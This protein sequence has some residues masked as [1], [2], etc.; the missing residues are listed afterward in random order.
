MVTAGDLERTLKSLL[1]KSS[2]LGDFLRETERW[3]EDAILGERT[4]WE[5]SLGLLPHKARS[6]ILTFPG[7][8]QWLEHHHRR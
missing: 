8:G 5:E 6:M 1:L 2:P 7:K 3:T 4:L